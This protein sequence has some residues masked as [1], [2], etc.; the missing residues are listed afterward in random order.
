MFWLGFVLCVSFSGC[1]AHQRE[2][3]AGPEVHSTSTTQ[4]AVRKPKDGA[5]K[6]PIDGTGGM[7]GKSMTLAKELPATRALRS[8]PQRQLAAA[9]TGRPEASQEYARRVRDHFVLLG[10]GQ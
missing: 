2:E 6:Q 3:T 7:P 1:L 9:E 8:K 4:R 5:V 10:P